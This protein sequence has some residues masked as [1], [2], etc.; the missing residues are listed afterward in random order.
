MFGKRTGFIA[1]AAAVLFSGSVLAQ[2]P[3]AF[4]SGFDPKSIELEVKFGSKALTDGDTLTPA[5]EL[6]FFLIWIGG[7]LTIA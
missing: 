1:A 2:I 3:D 4:T 7:S 5:G 6:G